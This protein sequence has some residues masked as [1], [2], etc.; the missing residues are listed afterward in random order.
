VEQW[1]DEV[2]DVLLS[3]EEKDKDDNTDN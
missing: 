3:S 1:L 2:K